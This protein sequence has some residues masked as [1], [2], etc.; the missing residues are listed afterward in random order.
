MGIFKNNKIA[1]PAEENIKPAAGD[2]GEAQP[3]QGGLSGVKHVIAVAS[4]KG[5]V[6]KSTLATNLAVALKQGGASVGLLDAD[7]YGPS[8]PGMLGAGHQELDI[9]DGQLKPVKRHGVD[10]VSMGLL[11][12]DDGPVVWRAPLATKMIMQFIA[13]VG[14]GNLDYLL[15]DLPPGTG[16]V[17]L[18][19]AQQASLTGAIIVTTPQEVALGVAKKGLKMFQQVNIPI[20]GVI[21]NMS[22][23]TCSHCG[24]VTHIFSSGG[25]K[26]LA[27]DMNVPFLG[28]VPLDPAIV[29]SGE[30]GVPVL[31]GSDD[32]AAGKAFLD[33]ADAI[34][35]QVDKAGK[36]R[37]IEPE[38]VGMTEAGD[39]VVRW[40][41]GLQGTFTPYDLRVNCPCAACIDEN[42][43]EKILDTSSVPLDIKINKIEPV[44][45][46]AVTLEFSDHHN[47]GIYRFDRLKQLALQRRESGGDKPQSFSV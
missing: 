10:F 25:G 41:D 35:D 31:T 32:S 2:S 27:E 16:D 11:I 8:Q 42:T 12:G 20:L 29:V 7:I 19:L 43:G 5:G 6:G 17:Q 26:R 14:W 22:G 24:E 45:R 15:V 18:T 23:F 46:Y 37:S 44:G 28:S 13:N 33:L 1:H 30:S 4:G 34:R 21:E 38:E 47:T 40:A 3:A 9:V 39:V 36:Q